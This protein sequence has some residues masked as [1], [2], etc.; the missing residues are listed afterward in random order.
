MGLAERGD[1]VGVAPAAAR[2]AAGERGECV[3]PVPGRFA[4]GRKGELREFSFSADMTLLSKSGDASGEERG[5]VG[6]AAKSGRETVRV[7]A[8][9]T[10]GL[11][12]ASGTM[13]RGDCGGVAGC[14]STSEE[15][16]QRGDVVRLARPESGRS[17]R[18]RLNS[19]KRTSAATSS[20]KV[21]CET[22][23]DAATAT[24]CIPCAGD[25]WRTGSVRPAMS[26][27]VATEVGVWKGVVGADVMASGD[28]GIRGLTSGLDSG[29]TMRAGA[30]ETSGVR[31]AV[32]RASGD[33]A[34]GA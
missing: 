6:E 17:A 33:D 13:T 18:P 10:P 7:S 24:T 11:G 26:A 5:E 31:A 15:S 19:R 2:I 29:A 8:F 22:A 14:R 34:R 21:V 25:S 4:R 30:K 32:P 23:M 12:D 1:A 20:E 9:S 16:E 27:H 3:A 28:E